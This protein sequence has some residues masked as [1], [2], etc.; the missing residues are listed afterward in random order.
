MTNTTPIYIDMPGPVALKQ[1]RYGPMVFLPNDQ[2]I[3]G[4]LNKYGEFSEGEVHLFR[5][6]V[7]ENWTVFDV[8]ANHG[9][10]T[11][12]LSQLVGRYGEVHSF[13]PQRILH[14]IVCANVALNSLQNVFTYQ[15]AVGK[16]SG[17][18]KVPPV[19]YT[20]YNNFGAVE[21]GGVSGETVPVITLDSLNL[22]SCHFA[23]IDAE[24]MEGDIVAGASGL[25]E[26]FKPILYME[27]DRE[28]KAPTLIQQMWELDYELFYHMPY[29]YNRFNFHSVAENIYGG[30]ISVNMLCV[31]RVSRVGYNM[32][33]LTIPVDCHKITSLTD[34]WRTFV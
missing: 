18:I 23:K 3:G 16:E 10:H 25:I 31:P 30:T 9:A 33:T 7:K 8:G 5:Q 1:C 19:D 29:Y 17:K 15:V 20:R 11:V 32:Q 4:A 26:R 21:L 27:N 28:D 24:G 12:A 22:N 14:Q 13:E 2:Y 6:I 34:T